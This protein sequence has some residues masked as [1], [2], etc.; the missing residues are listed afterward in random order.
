MAGMQGENL[1]ASG[2]QHNKH[3]Y[4]NQLSFT[5]SIVNNKK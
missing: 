1:I 5:Y 4:K 3:I 2:S